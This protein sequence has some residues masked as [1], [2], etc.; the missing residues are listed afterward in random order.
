M[1]FGIQ[2]KDGTKVL[3]EFVVDENTK[4]L[5][6]YEWQRRGIDYFFKHHKAIFQ[7][8]TGGGKT[9]FT[10]AIL[11]EL[12]KTYPDSRVLVVVPKNVILETT[13]FKELY[14]H[15]LTP[16]DV[17]VFYGEVKEYGKITIT[18]MQNIDT[19]ALE[20]FDVLVLDEVH[21]YATKRLLKQFGMNEFKYMI[22]LSA[23]IER[24]D[25]QHIKLYEMFD[26]NIFKYTPQEAMDDGV[27]NP[28]RFFNIGIVMDN[29]A[30]IEYESITQEL[31][32]ILKSGNGFIN[33]MQS[34]GDLK[35]KMLKLMNQR[36]ELM[37]NYPRKFDVIK[38]ICEK[39]KNDKVIVF[40]EFNSQTSKCYWY[41]LELG[42]KAGVVH[43]GVSKK[44][45]SQALIDFKNDKYNVLLCTR[46]LDEGYNLPKI[47]VGVIMAGNS[48]SRQ[49]IQRMGRVLR[50]KDV[51]SKLYQIYC[52]DTVE[53]TYAAKR[54]AL[55]QAL[56]TSYEQ[57]VYDGEKLI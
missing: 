23:T 9:F 6:L 19:V 8:P 44:R 53:D 40:N 5:S 27:I 29:E 25:K 20:M 30:F 1:G 12:F 3:S 26:Y 46:I 15:G 4:A 48:T 45:R 16:K 13:W 18:N 56:C 39:H 2:I 43:S 28:F 31:N 37:N 35:P 11:K 21:N 7:I 34:N 17:G 38:Q 50:K 47:D 51:E 52:M 33:I 32:L 55:F 10:I 42:L 14:N 57:F 41:L 22:G 54:A 36:K 49:T 24:M